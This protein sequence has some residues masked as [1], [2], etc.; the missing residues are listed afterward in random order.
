MSNRLARESSPYLRQHAH[1]PVDWFPWGDEAIEKA[2]SER[3]PIFVSVGY[4]TCYW[5]HVMERE[6]FE[7]QAIA[8]QLSRDFVSVKVDREERPDV[9]DAMMSACQIYTAWT[10]GRAS[11]GWPLTVFLDPDS[12]RPFFAGTY[13]PPVPAFGRLSFPDLLTQ[14]AAAWRDTPDAVRAQ[15]SK[16]FQ[17]MR[18]SI[19]G[20][21]EDQSLSESTPRPR[22]SSIAL[23]DL[24]T[25][26]AR[27]L[28]SYEDKHNGG[29]GGAPKF[30]QPSWLELMA[31]C[32]AEIPE[33]AQVSTRALRALTLG[34]IHDH[35]GGGFHRYSVDAMWRVPHFEKMLY[36]SAQLVPLLCSTNDEWLVRAATR[37]LQWM[38][39][40][41]LRDDGL[42]HTAQDAEVD[43]R[44]GLNF[45]WTMEEIHAALTPDD[46][47]VACTM[48]G[49]DAGTNFTDPHHRESPA[50]NV[51]FLSEVPAPEMW[52][53][54]DR[55]SESLRLVRALRKQPNTDDKALLSWNALAIRAFAEA[56]RLVRDD[57]LAVEYVAQATRS[58]DA[59]WSAFVEVVHDDDVGQRIETMWRVR[60]GDLAPV[61][62]ALEDVACFAHAATAL[63]D[64]TNDPRFHLAA[65][66]LLD[67][68]TRVHLDSEARWC[69]RA[70]IDQWGLRGK[71]VHD[72]A[73]PS[74][75]GTMALVLARLARGTRE[76]CAQARTLAARTL[77]T[78]TLRAAEEPCLAEPTQAARTLAA[79]HASK[80]LV[81]PECL[82]AV[83]LTGK[84]SHRTLT[85]SFA[86]GWHVMAA[87]TS[88]MGTTAS[89]AIELVGD[90]VTSVVTQSRGAIDDVPA[91]EG[92]VPITIRLAPEA[93]RAVLRFQPCTH[94]HC[95]AHIEM[96]IEF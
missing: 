44:E 75:A 24:A 86:T 72:G 36:D 27:G 81:L 64:A 93:T 22:V 80:T 33:C 70:G 47:R 10:E 38:T 88:T 49:L 96:T 23:P 5:C 69:E 78:R 12:L 94:T 77:L 62:A 30:P 14:V 74:G 18:E 63:W 90:G 13:F 67:Y 15:A 65:S 20:S 21:G 85:V 53:R 46:A 87:N 91:Y 35:L 57:T 52:D 56:G 71:S 19:D 31:Q 40:E 3:K 76:H 60:R 50:S 26:A 39:R 7:D 6:C 25:R 89:N 61:G 32:A 34:G 83:L 95:L 4:S 92:E 48:L 73:M 59:A 82:D 84:G 37:A 45:L 79:A 1:N 29:F 28:L 8:A 17:A 11:G 58:F 68:A 2:R 16:I 9:D 51:L 66:A 41:M 42:F 55:I 43:G 54:L